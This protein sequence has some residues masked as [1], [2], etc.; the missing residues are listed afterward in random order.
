MR[1][2]SLGKHQREVVLLIHGY[3]HGTGK[4]FE[5]TGHPLED[6][7]NVPLGPTPRLGAEARNRASAANQIK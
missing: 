6:L 7:I 1:L 5:F 3:M 4:C 2:P